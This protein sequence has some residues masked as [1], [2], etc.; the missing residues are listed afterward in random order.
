MKEPRWVEGYRRLINRKLSQLFSKSELSKLAREV[1]LAEGKRFRPVLCFLA[2]EAV[3]GKDTETALLVAC[4]CE[5]GHAASLIQDDII[6]DTYFRRGK[7]TIFGKCGL[8]KSMLV[9]DILV[10][11]SYEISSQVAKLA[12]DRISE[13][14]EITSIAQRDTTEGEN[15]DLSFN[16]KN[17]I[18][19]EKYFNMIK[20]KTASLIANSAKAGAVVGKAT[21][22]QKKSLY[23]FGM[24]MGMV[25][26]IKDDL[27]D[28]FGESEEIGKPIFSDLKMGKVTLPI[29]YAIN[30]LC[31]TD[32]D[33]LKNL[34]G[35]KEISREDIKKTR[36]LLSRCGAVD[37][38]K[39]VAQDLLKK[40]MQSL[41][42]LPNTSAKMRLNGVAEMAYERAK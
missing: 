25:F 16:L 38:S 5:L 30:K 20:M 22:Q 31:G 37:Y 39:K 42:I 13:L 1:V 28:I 29:I 12:P 8:N 40:A 32:K 4:Q 19:E 7:K 6:D 2:H 15:L 11:K 41:E 33:F 27:L 17:G 34:I 36:N 26:Q 10:A 21:D 18:T 24:Y 9:F 23:D 14:L 35:R 3:G